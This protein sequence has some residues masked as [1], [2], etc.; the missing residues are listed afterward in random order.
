M[1]TDDYMDD[2]MRLIEAV[3]Q[4]WGMRAAVAVGRMLE[5]GHR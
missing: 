5:G 4:A 3:E 2:D 1:T